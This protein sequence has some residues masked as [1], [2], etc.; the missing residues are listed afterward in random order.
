MYEINY[1]NTFKK[2]LKRMK[3]RGYD[4]ALFEEVSQLLQENGSL[5]AIYSPH[6]LSGKLAGFW[7]CHIQSDW[8]LIWKQD[9]EELLLLYT[10]TGTHSDLF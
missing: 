9:N 2:S 8:L 5:P 4:M 3:K 1:T 7:E 6:K 10:D